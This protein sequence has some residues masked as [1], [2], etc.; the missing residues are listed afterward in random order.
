MRP[1]RFAIRQPSG[2]AKGERRIERAVTRFD[3][4]V[5]GGGTAGIAASLAAAHK[6]AHVALVESRP[7]LGGE[8]TFTGCVPSKDLCRIDDF[9][10]AEGDAERTAPD[11]H[12]AEGA[13]GV[14]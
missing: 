5:V 9:G 1:A 8:C 2:I 6:G 7:R 10:S 11:D 4:I 12:G 13:R 14:S 3:V